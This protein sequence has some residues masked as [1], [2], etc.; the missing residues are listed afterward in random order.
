MS[1]KTIVIAQDFSPFPGGRFRNDGPNS[2][3]RFRDELLIPALKEF[4]R[5]IVILDGTEGFG[6]SFLDE[7]FGGIIRNTGFSSDDLH[8]KLIIASDD[9]SYSDEVW[10][11][12]E[13]ANEDAR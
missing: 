6:S 8:T 1:E 3:E 2:G 11:F 13:K 12:I 7:A 4:E 10:E 5:V 9:P